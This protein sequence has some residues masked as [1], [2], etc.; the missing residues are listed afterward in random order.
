M[1][2]KEAG[3][4]GIFEQSVR[5]LHEKLVVLM[6]VTPVASGTV[7]VAGEGTG[8]LSDA[9]KSSSEKVHEQNLAVRAALEELLS[10]STWNSE[11]ESRVQ[12]IIRRIEQCERKILYYQEWEQ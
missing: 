10:S 9:E 7:D 5:E 2:K 11:E 8:I 12:G 4:K 1:K 6:S 3:E